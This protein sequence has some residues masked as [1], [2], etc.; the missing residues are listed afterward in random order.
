MTVLVLDK[1][2][3]PLMPCTPKRARKLLAAGRARIHRLFPFCIRLVDRCL[4]QSTVQPLRL[5]IDPGSKAT[6]MAIARIEA[7]NAYGVVEPVIH[8]L[9]LL[10]LAHRGQAIRDSLHARSAMRHR[11]RSNLR[12]RAPR[13]S[14]RTRPRGWLPPSLRHRLDTTVSWVTRLRR[15]APVT[16]L[17]QELVYFDTQLMQDPEISGV[18][19]QQGT[20]AGSEVRE[21]LLEK[22]HRT[23][24]YCDA[25]DVPLQ[26]EHIHAKA[27]GGSDRVSNLTLACIPC[28]RKKSAQDIRVFLGKD[29][30]R[31]ARILKQAKAPLHDAAAVNATRWVLF[32][33]LKKAGLPVETGTGGQTKWNRSRHGVI[34]THALDAAC[35]GV[36]GEVQG[37]K[38]PTLHVK[39]TGRGSRCKT[40]L[41]KYGFPRAYLTRKKT[42]F[43]FRTGDMVMAT[44]LTGKHKGQ[45]RGRVAVRMTG[46]FNIQLGIA[47]IPT[48][49]GV[50]HRYCRVLQRA[51]G[52]GYVWQPTNIFQIK[53]KATAASRSAPFLTALNGGVFRSTS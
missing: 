13:F 39:C 21:Y 41:D 12:Y 25:T 7:A 48:V 14:N 24:T 10:E 38:V 20:L 36:V 19:Y 29:P 2:K 53:A 49:Q 23:C 40:R 30:V 52:Y 22:F 35:V 45:Y 43:G 50:A 1:K 17:A 51:D 4:E 16:H 44:V 27:R 47:G 31:L 3:R 37:T 15:L 26:V 6:G 11:R 5:S 42:A 8:I 32:C 9:F 18:A 28:N 46:N 34:K 33:A